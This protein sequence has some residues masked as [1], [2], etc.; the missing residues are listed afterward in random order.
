LVLTEHPREELRAELISST[1]LVEA[2]EVVDDLSFVNQAKRGHDD[3][4]KL[5]YQVPVVDEE[6][7]LA[8]R[9]IIARNK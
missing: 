7:E 9:T 2:G 3:D 4:A 1:E 8:T 5:I 6:R